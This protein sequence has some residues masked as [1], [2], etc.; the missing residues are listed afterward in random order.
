[1]FDRGAPCEEYRGKMTAEVTR[2]RYGCRSGRRGK[3]LAGSSEN[4]RPAVVKPYKNRTE[5]VL[6]GRFF[7]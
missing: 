3:R 7:R 2:E 4:I 1:M 6:T 5:L